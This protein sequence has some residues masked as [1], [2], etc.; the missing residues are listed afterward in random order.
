MTGWWWFTM[1]T[2]L[3]FWRITLSK[4]LQPLTP[5]IP[6]LQTSCPPRGARFA[7]SLEPASELRTAR[8]REE[9]LTC[10]SD[11]SDKVWAFLIFHPGAVCKL[12]RPADDLVFTC[13]YVGHPGLILE[14]QKTSQLINWC[15]WSRQLAPL[16]AFSC[17]TPEI[18]KPRSCTF[19]RLSNLPAS[20]GA[21]HAV[22]AR[23]SACRMCQESA[24]NLWQ[25]PNRRHVPL[26]LQTAA[27]P[28]PPKKSTAHMH[29]RNFSMGKKN[30][31]LTG[32][33]VTLQSSQEWN[34]RNRSLIPHFKLSS[35]E[36][37]CVK[38]CYRLLQYIMYISKCGSEQLSHEATECSTQD[39]G[40]VEGPSMQA[41]ACSLHTFGCQMRCQN[42]R[43]RS[44]TA[45]GHDDL[46][47][48]SQLS[49]SWQ[50]RNN[51]APMDPIRWCCTEP[52]NFRKNNS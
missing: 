9:E 35:A 41:Q 34:F 37:P 25:R 47:V 27:H 51:R 14:T 7:L 23:P 33:W 52:P 42:L 11:K 29:T 26:Q 48:R 13:F 19:Q 49:H 20:S 1:F 44:R 16:S 5:W 3:S 12:R 15:H 40:H 28:D 17:A 24:R 43:I 2:F 8:A 30:V 50:W 18:Q 38:M 21:P 32:L 6:S 4:S 39:I 10:T 31:S 22:A 36:D 45:S 46:C